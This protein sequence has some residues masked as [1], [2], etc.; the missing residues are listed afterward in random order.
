[1]RK[2]MLKGWLFVGVCLLTF[3]A[4][5][6]KVASS[7]IFVESPDF[8]AESMTIDL[9]MLHVS[10]PPQQR[11]LAFSN[12]G[13]SALRLVYKSSTCGCTQVT[14][15]DETVEPGKRGLVQVTVDPSQ[16]G[17]GEKTQMIAFDTNDPDE[18]VIIFNVKWKTSS[19]APVR[20]SPARV[21]VDISQ[22]ELASN[23]AAT[24]LYCTVL[25]AWG[26][27]LRV[28][29]LQT[30][31][32]VSATMEEKWYKC[33]FCETSKSLHTFAIRTSLKPSLPPGQVD[34]WV[35]F[36]TNHPDY[37][38]VV[39]PIRGYVQGPVT[40][41]PK[42]L[43]FSS[44]ES[45]VSKRIWV[46]HTKLT[47]LPEEIS[48]AADVAWLRVVPSD[49]STGE[50]SV[51]VDREMVKAAV[52]TS[53]ARGHVLIQ[54]PNGADTKLPVAYVWDQLSEKEVSH[55]AN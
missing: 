8:A 41:T 19:K 44:N 4:G 49:V 27:N 2:T 24:T 21:E 9:G 15:V 17:T 37:P 50:W 48:V 34:E 14:T 31:P 6:W 53:V 54:A 55:I 45:T 42:A 12:T 33:E 39:I 16:A 18:P 32:N 40:I 51:A 38:Q 52:H 20:V 5:I 26:N 22:S 10:S 29:S 3:G 13:G 36:A 28:S 25:D 11:S 46:K 7:S 23:G 47:K 43:T 35:K 1:M 30:S